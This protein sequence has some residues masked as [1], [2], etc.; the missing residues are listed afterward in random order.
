MIRCQWCRQESQS[1]DV[2][3]WC[4]RPIVA[5]WKPAALG[6]DIVAAEDDT[7]SVAGNDRLLLLSMI[8]VGVM[9]VVALGY[10][11]LIQQAPPAPP[12][13]PAPISTTESVAT[14]APVIQQEQF[15]AIPEQ[16]IQVY[17]PP[18]P[19]VEPFQTPRRISDLPPG[20]K[21]RRSYESVRELN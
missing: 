21:L 1:D 19:V 4:R 2:C 9:T 8:G 11:Y 20:G 14:R 17:T 7:E 16:P 18:P 15:A 12:P 10:S 3:E 5:G 6:P 13:S